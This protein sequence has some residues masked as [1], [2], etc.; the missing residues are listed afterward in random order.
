MEDFVYYNNLYD[1]YGVLLTDNEKECFVDYYQ[2]NLSLSEIAENRNVSR[3]AISKTVKTVVDK[4]KYY[5][6]NLHIYQKNVELIELLSV[7]KIE[8]LKDKIRVIIEK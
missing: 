7:S 8:E 2:E 3:S 1:I 6:N 5:E 4:L